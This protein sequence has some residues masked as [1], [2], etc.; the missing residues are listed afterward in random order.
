MEIGQQPMM[1]SQEIK[2]KPSTNLLVK[3][4]SYSVTLV[5][6]DSNDCI[7]KYIDKE[8][9]EKVKPQRLSEKLDLIINESKIII[10]NIIDVKLIVC[11]KLSCLVPKNLFEEKLSLEYLKFNS[12]LLKNDFAANDTI[13]E[14]GAVNVFLPF[15]NV[16]NYLIDK[17]GSFNYYHYSTILIKKLIKHNRK[18]DTSVYAN[19]Q[20]NNFQVLIFK[21]KNLIYYNNFEIK[22]K[23]DILYFIL[24]SIEQNKIDN[25]KSKVSLLGEIKSESEVYLLLSKFIV[26]IEIINFEEEKKSIIKN[27][28]NY[29]N[30]D[31]LII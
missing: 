14:I 23:E 17:F 26:N 8:F 30:I 22:D 7:I 12:K 28:D 5:L 1:Q 31:Y 19:I 27:I 10:S 16:N 4:G 9:T 18:K 29:S 25:S 20:L 3:L 2:I 15:V 24:L 21:S 6:S 11:N 13:E